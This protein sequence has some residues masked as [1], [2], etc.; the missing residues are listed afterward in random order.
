M[1]MTVDGEKPNEEET[2]ATKKIYSGS[3][4]SEAASTSTFW[5]LIITF[6]LI[7]FA[8]HSVI[9]HFIPYMRDKGFSSI[10]AARF[11]SIVG[12]C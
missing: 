1:G 5:T 12:V 9:T 7:A 8:L 2:P 3:S 6:L 11:F 10:L 4:V